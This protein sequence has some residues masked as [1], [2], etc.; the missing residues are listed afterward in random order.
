MEDIGIIL[1]FCLFLLFVSTMYK[2]LC[3]N[4][5]CKAYIFCSVILIFETAST[6]FNSCK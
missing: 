6:V 5:F 1:C 3:E 4:D 2:R